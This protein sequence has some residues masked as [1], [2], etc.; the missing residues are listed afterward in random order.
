MIAL[1]SYNQRFKIG[2]ST[3]NE[4]IQSLLNILLNVLNID[5]KSKFILIFSYKYDF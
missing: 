3:I 5:N 2:F 1:F 4:D